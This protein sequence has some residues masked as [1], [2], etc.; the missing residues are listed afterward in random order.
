MREGR[1]GEEANNTINTDSNA[2]SKVSAINNKSND[3]NDIFREAIF[4]MAAGLWVSK[5]LATALELQVFSKLSGNKSVTLTEL[6]KLLGMESRPTEALVTALV[7][8]RLLKV[9]SDQ[10][11]ERIYS[12]SGISETFLDVSKANSYIG[13]IAT[14]FDKHFYKNWDKLTDCLHSNKPVE[15]IVSEK[16]TA[17]NRK[18]KSGYSSNNN[19][20]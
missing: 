20:R 14:I 13:D 19:N 5:T 2:S 1:E 6:Q 4:N 9:S 7:S 11:G 17:K 12:N 3:K 18:T 16:N 10:T 8:L 15:E